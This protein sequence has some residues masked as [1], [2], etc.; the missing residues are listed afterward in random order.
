MGVLDIPSRYGRTLPLSAG[1]ELLYPGSTLPHWKSDKV[2][3]ATTYQISRALAVSVAPLG[4][5]RGGSKRYWI[6]VASR[7]RVCLGVGGSFSQFCYGKARPL[8]RIFGY[9]EIPMLDFELIASGMLGCIS[10]N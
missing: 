8:K 1:L 3:R 6:G 2:E 5:E 10:T 4:V 7:E 9:L